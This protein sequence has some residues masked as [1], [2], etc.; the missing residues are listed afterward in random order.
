[1]PY[2]AAQSPVAPSS[3]SRLWTGGASAGVS[4]VV[5]LLLAIFQP[6]L[7]PWLIGAAL[8][9]SV[10]TWAINRR[11]RSAAVADA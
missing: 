5:L 6:T 10:S 7:A 4:V 3:A 2:E 1:M 8:L 9:V 11:P